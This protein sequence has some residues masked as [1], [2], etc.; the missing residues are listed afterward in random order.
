[1]K[2]FPTLGNEEILEG[3][4]IA[5]EILALEL[6]DAMFGADAT[7]ITCH[8]VQHFGGQPL[9]M[10]LKE[11][12]RCAGRTREIVVKIAI[13]EMTEHDQAHTGVMLAD[14]FTCRG[15]D[16]RNRWYRL[17]DVMLH[18]WTVGALRFGDFLAKPPHAV[19]LR[20]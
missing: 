18:V 10:K 19:H 15:K 13:A 4:F 14:T 16:R 9:S 17:P 6:S 7:A 12:A 2:T 1:M 5:A 8:F 20:N 3:V 11:I